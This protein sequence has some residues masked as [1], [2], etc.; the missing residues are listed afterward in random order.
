LY[1]LLSD[2]LGT[3]TRLRSYTLLD[4]SRSAAVSWSRQSYYAGLVPSAGLVYPTQAAVYPIDPLPSEAKRRLRRLRWDEDQNLIDG[5]LGPRSLTQL[6][7]VHADRSDLRLEIAR[8]ADSATT[9]V[10]NGLGPTLQYLLVRD[11][12]DCFWGERISPDEQVE[13]KRIEASDAED[14]LRRILLDHEPSVPLGLE[15]AGT[16]RSYRTFYYGNNVDGQFGQP[17]PSSSILEQCFDALRDFR[18]PDGKSFVA[19]TS[20]A[21]STVPVGVPQARQEAGLHVIQGTW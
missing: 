9:T 15:I 1:A 12:T 11:G 10:R 14:Q 21:P 4:G 2:G 19:I 8:A 16:F 18:L 5:Y 7:V 3:R 17:T 20:E 6:M 13:L